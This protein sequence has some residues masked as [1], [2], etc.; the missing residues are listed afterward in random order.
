MSSMTLSIDC[1][2][3]FIKSCVLDE[4]GTMHAAPTR[5]ET[6]YPLTTKRFLDEAG[7]S[8]EETVL[9]NVIPGW[10]GTRDIT[11][12]ERAHVQ[13]PLGQ[14]LSLLPLVKAVVLVGNEAKKWAGNYLRHAHSSLELFESTH[15]SPMCRL[16]WN[17]RWQAIPDEWRKAADCIHA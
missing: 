14:L 13:Q 15:P 4:S 8:R 6:P 7:F 11:P 3:L 5:V 16:S 10:N 2:G 17:T 1:G 12:A 9:W